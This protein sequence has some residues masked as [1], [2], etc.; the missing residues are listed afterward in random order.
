MFFI[1]RSRSR[2][3]LEPGVG[4]G[5]R[6]T[7]TP[8]F[9]CPKLLVLFCFF[10]FFFFYILNWFT[11]GPNQLFLV[12]KYIYYLSRNVK[13]HYF[14]GKYVSI[15]QISVKLLLSILFLVK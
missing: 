2:T 11:N 6:R 12:S 8:K 15:G 13:I 3:V 10:F 9:V 1:H 5:K 14:I 7:P 4:V